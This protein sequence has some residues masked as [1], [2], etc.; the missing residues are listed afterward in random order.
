MF[1]YLARCICRVVLALVK[2]W[3]V[4]GAANLPAEGGLVL[5]ANH[6]SYWDPVVVGCA[7]NRRVNFMGKAE[8]FENPVLNPI[9]RALGTFPIRRGGTDRTAI[10]TAL[11]LLE[12]GQIV[13]VFPEGARS[14]NGELQKPH[15]GAA[16]LALKVGVPMLPVAIH[17][18]KGHFGKITINIGRPI[19]YP[20]DARASR[21]DLEK[22]SDLIMAQIAVLLKAG[23]R[24]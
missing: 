24:N 13:G 7:I 18:G 20:V 22:A 17:I 10:R 5:V 16:M 19:I 2:R 9:I 8:L 11:A 1:Y 12:K 3:E 15:L 6:T 4:R 21:V 14:Q 23:K